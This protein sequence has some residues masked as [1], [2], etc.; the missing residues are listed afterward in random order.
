M[1]DAKQGIK[2]VVYEVLDMFAYAHKDLVEMWVKDNVE[3]TEEEILVEDSRYG[4]LESY[5]LRLTT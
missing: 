2:H 1:P 3:V 5:E 4:Y